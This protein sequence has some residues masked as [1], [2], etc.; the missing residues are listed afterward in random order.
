MS[1]LKTTGHDELGKEA[2]DD[3]PPGEK[4]E[5]SDHRSGD[6]D[7]KTGP[8]PERFRLKVFILES[9]NEEAGEKKSESDDGEKTKTDEKEGG[10]K[11]DDAPAE[12]TTP[13]KMKAITT[14][15]Y[16]GITQ[17]AFEE[18][19]LADVRSKIA[20]L[21]SNPFRFCDESGAISQDEKTLSSYINE[22]KD[23]KIT[24]DTPIN[25]YVTSFTHPKT[26]AA[27]IL[28]NPPFVLK[29][30]QKLKGDELQKESM[31]HS[32]LLPSIAGGK[33]K[34]KEIR[35]HVKAMSAS[36]SRHQFCL[37]DGHTVDDELSLR[38][39]VASL[40][41]TV[42]T[43]ETPQ[44][45]SSIEIYFVKPGA[46]KK[47]KDKGASDEIKDHPA[48]KPGD[49]TFRD[50]EAFNAKRD[51]ELREVK[52]ELDAANFKL[53]GGEDDAKTAGVLTEDEWASI[54]QNC[55]LMF[56]WVVDL[57]KNR[58]V[59]APKAAFQLRN[60]L[61][62]EVA[63]ATTEPDEP[64]ANPPADPTPPAEGSSPPPA[65]SAPTPPTKARG[66][67]HFAINDD[68]RHLVD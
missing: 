60:G 45:T 30:I 40:S 62:M 26:S 48:L 6:K 61:N 46:I 35:K 23:T 25:I 3:Q 64:P 44:A 47:S 51:K 42:D 36:T 12:S 14:V 39:Y 52:E 1:V 24:P 20:S 28:D 56:G 57:S 54:I 38:E 4:K 63:S 58:V 9:T 27:E 16:K 7:S 22:L 68:S 2:K 32:S 59:C 67:P 33:I 19:T 8:K 50:L 37:K 18:T 17:A 65:P 31:I 66:I 34:L 43:D 10:G 29:F 55:N 11:D 49:L 41:K 21:M 13:P 15:E 5:E 53:E